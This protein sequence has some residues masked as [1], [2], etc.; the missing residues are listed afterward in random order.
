[1]TDIIYLVYIGLFVITIVYYITFS[2]DNVS[3]III[4]RGPV[5]TDSEATYSN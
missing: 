1:M 2:R 3:P 5:V 4:S